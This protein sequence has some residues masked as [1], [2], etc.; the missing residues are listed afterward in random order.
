MRL[1]TTVTKT[2]FGLAIG[3]LLGVGVAAVYAQAVPPPAPAP[4]CE[5]QLEDAQTK[6]LEAQQAKAQAEYR[7]SSVELYARA[8]KKQLDAA[9][10]VPAAPKAA[11]KEGK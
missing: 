1:F 8:C 4:T 10:S 5:V 2:V 6:L 11:Q 9:K 7:A 3:S